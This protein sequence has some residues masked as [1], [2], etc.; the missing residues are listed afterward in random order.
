MRLA[1]LTLTLG[2]AMKTAERYF[3]DVPVYRIAEDRYLEELIR[4]TE[5]VLFPADDPLS[6]TLRERDR[7]NPA[8]NEQLRAHIAF[9]YGGCW[10]YNEIVGYIRLFFLGSQIRGEY[11]GISQKRAIRTRHKVFV[12]KSLK[13]AP[14][15]EIPSG[16]SN[17]SIFEFVL[18]YLSDCRAEL[19]QRHIGSRL[20]EEVGPHIN[21]Q[22]LVPNQ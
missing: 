1:P 2:V 16:A 14:E 7:L 20:L 19:P 18:Q 3:Y 9:K 5:K 13:L 12:L 11:F 15:R 10:Q 4:H 22:V 21:W 17:E 6:A 8:E